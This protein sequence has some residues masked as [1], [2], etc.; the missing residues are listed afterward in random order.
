MRLWST[1]LPRISEPDLTESIEFSIIFRE[2]G[3]FE[4]SQSENTDTR[5]VSGGERDVPAVEARPVVLVVAPDLVALC[6]W[7][8][9]V[10][11][12]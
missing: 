8:A 12:V 10:V 1:K 6:M 7:N 5:D 3:V 9:F 2:G 4:S 11:L